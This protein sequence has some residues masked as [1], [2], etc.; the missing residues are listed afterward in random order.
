MQT[1]QLQ[2]GMKKTP[3]VGGMAYCNAPI[4]KYK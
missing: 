3:P 1:D 4:S 2:N